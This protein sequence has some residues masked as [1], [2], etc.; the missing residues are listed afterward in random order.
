MFQVENQTPLDEID[1]A[2]PK[3]SRPM[4]AIKTVRFENK[5]A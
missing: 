5:V 1:I 3:S 2:I 4:S